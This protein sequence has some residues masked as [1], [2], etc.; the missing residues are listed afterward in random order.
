MTLLGAS[1][2]KSSG[3]RF[4]QTKTIITPCGLFSPHIMEES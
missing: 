1:I 4:N 3:N 2:G